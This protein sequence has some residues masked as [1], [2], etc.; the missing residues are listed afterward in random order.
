MSIFEKCY[1]CFLCLLFKKLI[2]SIL[3][4][5][6][7]HSRLAHQYY[8]FGFSPN[9]NLPHRGWRCHFSHE[10]PHPSPFFTAFGRWTDFLSGKFE[11]GCAALLYSALRPQHPGCLRGVHFIFGS[12]M[13]APPTLVFN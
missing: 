5:K 6:L 13:E 1:V 9:A 2:Y 10:G 8:A 12:E 7:Y 3:N 11:N 4:H